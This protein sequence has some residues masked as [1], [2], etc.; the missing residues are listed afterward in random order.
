MGE[1]DP[2]QK[3]EVKKSRLVTNWIWNLQANGCKK[4]TVG[5]PSGAICFESRL[6]QLTQRYFKISYFKIRNVLIFYLPCRA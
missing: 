6:K 5:A 1:H 2:R 3:A 4:T